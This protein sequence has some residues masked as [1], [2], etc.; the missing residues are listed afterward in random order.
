[1]IIHVQINTNSYLLNTEKSVTHGL[2]DEIM[3]EKLETR[4]A[5]NE[6]GNDDDVEEEEH[7]KAYV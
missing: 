4:I 5:S 1:M 2:S 6:I 3:N 7:A